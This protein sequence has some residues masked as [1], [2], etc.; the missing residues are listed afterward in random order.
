[1]TVVNDIFFLCRV[2]GKRSLKGL[3]GMLLFAKK[4]NLGEI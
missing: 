1:M 4:F 2:R 3:K